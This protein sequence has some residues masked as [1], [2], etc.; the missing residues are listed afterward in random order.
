MIAVLRSVTLGLALFVLATACAL[1]EPPPTAGTVRL[2]VEVRN[3][4]TDLVEL[5]VRTDAGE[6]PGAVQPASVAPGSSADVFISVPID[7]AWTLNVEPAGWSVESWA[8]Q[9]LLDQD[10]EIV[11]NLWAD[12]GRN[13]A[14]A[15]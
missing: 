13:L 7:R 10:C 14:C 2:Q 1:V 8:I 12:D 5:V 11:L 4:S 3:A 9:A 15:R 6:L